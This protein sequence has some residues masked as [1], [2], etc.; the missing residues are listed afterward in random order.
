[1]SFYSD[2]LAHKI[3]EECIASVLERTMPQPENAVEMICYQAMCKIKAILDDDS[4]SDPECF[5]K[6]E[7][8]VNVFESIGSNGGSRHD[9]G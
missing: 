6:I 1:M 7:E 2:I 3:H 8:I 5:T 9:F 4:P